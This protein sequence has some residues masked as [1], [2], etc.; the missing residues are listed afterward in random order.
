MQYGFYK[1]AYALQIHHDLKSIWQEVKK[2]KV[3]NL[4]V[5]GIIVKGN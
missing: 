1:K 2:V 3:W 5:W 4:T